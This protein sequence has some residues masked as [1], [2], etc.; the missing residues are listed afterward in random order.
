M[1]FRSMGIINQEYWDGPSW[2]GY[3]E[4]ADSMRIVPGVHGSG[5]QLGNKGKQRPIIPLFRKDFV[6]QK[7]IASAILY[8]S[9]LG[10]YDAYL[11]GAKIGDGFLTP[12]WTD[13]DKTVFYNTYD[14]K[15]LLKKGNK[16]IAVI[17]GKGFYNIKC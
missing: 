15:P 16:A 11:N 14:V 12:G 8:I 1:L 9:G 6:L 4:L 3:E 7:A 5:Y 2:I 17:V 13:Y 10:Q